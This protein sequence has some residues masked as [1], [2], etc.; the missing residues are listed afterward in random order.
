M[1]HQR[2]RY[3][4]LRSTASSPFH[5]L[6]NPSFFDSRSSSSCVHST[7]ASPLNT[8]SISLRSPDT[9]S[10]LT[11]RFGNVVLYYLAN[12]QSTSASSPCDNSLF[13]NRILLLDGGV[14]FDCSCSVIPL[15]TCSTWCNCI[16]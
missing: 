16:I 14:G 6:N 1:Q 8:L 15:I 13:G 11:S 7:F 9:L 3:F 12:I 2:L 5:L 4:F 10:S